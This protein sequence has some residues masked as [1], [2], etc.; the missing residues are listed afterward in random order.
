MPTFMHDEIRVYPNDPDPA[1]PRLRRCLEHSS[2]PL[3]ADYAGL[4]N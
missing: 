3:I 2:A 1:R 4:P